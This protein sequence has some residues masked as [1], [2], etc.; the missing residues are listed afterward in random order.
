MQMVVEY[1][2]LEGEVD[3]R[4]TARSVAARPTEEEKD[5]NSIFHLHIYDCQICEKSNF[6]HVD[7]QTLGSFEARFPL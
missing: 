3:L 6:L 1:G 2:A 5:A 4:G 7:L